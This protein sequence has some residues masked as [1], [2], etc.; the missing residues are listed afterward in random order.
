MSIGASRVESQLTLLS[1]NE[2]TH[3]AER[4]ERISAKRVPFSEIALE[5]GYSSTAFALAVFRNPKM[6]SLKA[7]SDSIYS[8]LRPEDGD[9]PRYKEAWSTFRFAAMNKTAALKEHLRYYQDL[10]A[11]ARQ[12]FTLNSNV[13]PPAGLLD[14][15][16]EPGLDHKVRASHLSRDS[17]INLLT[18][19][20]ALLRHKKTTGRLPAQLNELSPGLLR[21]I[22][23]DPLTGSANLPYHYKTSNAPSGFELY[24]V[25]PDM[26]DHGGKPG[27]YP[28]DAGYDIVA[29]HIS[30]NR[31][32]FP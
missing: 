18:I 9:K 10:A 19:E 21:T 24:G 12:P 32:L 30:R 22:P 4:L 17:T 14:E 1:D 25:G 13:M 5:E 16:F 31:K 3:A 28:G 26:T 11:E 8:Y 29:G 27:K 6:N 20:V 2:L 23:I 7:Y 15:E